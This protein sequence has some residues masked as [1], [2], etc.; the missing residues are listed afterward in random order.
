[1]S[2]SIYFIFGHRGKELEELGSDSSD[3]N[4]DPGVDRI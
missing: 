2:W 4:S 1:M 3:K